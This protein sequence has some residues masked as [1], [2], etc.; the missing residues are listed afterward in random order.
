VG[1][2]AAF[3]FG[4][5][6]GSVRWSG[7]VRD[8]T[9][10]LPERW[11][12]LIVCCWRRHF[13][14]VPSFRYRCLYRPVGSKLPGGLHSV[15]SAR[16]GAATIGSDGVGGCH[17]AQANPAA[18]ATGEITG[19]AAVGEAYGGGQRLPA[20]HG[21]QTVTGGEVC[22]PRSRNMFGDR[23]SRFVCALNDC[24]IILTSDLRIQCVV[25]CVLA[26]QSLQ[27]AD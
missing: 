20:G 4:S 7:S 24:V 21:Q 3:R 2:F 14:Q 6:V 12:V 8:R 15:T 5:C 11:G 22:C 16:Q 10:H 23:L 18:A 26:P 19:S 9:G 27:G 13:C 25:S 17:T 1:A